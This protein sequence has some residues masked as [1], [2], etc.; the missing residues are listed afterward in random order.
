M[1]AA[2]ALS[3]PA[4]LCHAQCGAQGGEG[5]KSVPK[6]AG[7][8]AT[9]NEGA[10]QNGEGLNSV[11]LAAQT[12]PLRCPRRHHHL[13][14]CLYDSPYPGKFPLNRN[15]FQGAFQQAELIWPSPDVTNSS[16]SIKSP[17][18]ASAITSE[19]R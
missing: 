8:K 15:F 10:T 1:A 19:S 18:A 17:I 6:K 12:F 4:A 14:N 13:N 9:G 11:T 16:S 3:S 5:K 7:C 2:T